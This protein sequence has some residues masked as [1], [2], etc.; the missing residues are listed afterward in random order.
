MCPMA[1]GVIMRLSDRSAL[2]LK[3]LVW[4]RVPSFL[5]PILLLSAWALHAQTTRE[6]NLRICLSGR[7]PTLC[8]HS[9]L[10]PDQLKLAREAE[11]RENLRVC[12]TG[13]FPSLCD[14][15]KLTESERRAVQ[16]AERQ[17][18][19]RVCLTGRFPTLCNHSRLTPSELQ[20]VRE[21]ERNENLRV[22]LD[23]RFPA[24][25]NKA[26][27]TPQERERATAAEAAAKALADAASARLG[28]RRTPRVQADRVGCESGHW[29]ESV[30][31]DGKIIKLEDGSMWEVDDVDTV[32]SSIWLPIS[33][34][35]VCNNKII[36]VD[37]GES[38]TASPLSPT[39]SGGGVTPSGK[40]A[41][42][43]DASH[44]DET[45]IINGEVFKAKT[46]CFNM[47]E[48]D[49]VVFLSGSAL[50]ACASAELLNLRTGKV[51]RVWCE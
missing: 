51:C 8:N 34:V 11:R 24:M 3:H 2:R 7:Y 27:L 48:G 10:T 28:G 33:E 5:I 46:Y 16:E 37:D 40:R 43:V 32:I 44:N 17:Q 41:Y 4:I 21:A 39:T 30:A 12:M 45:F 9:L 29:I 22:C 13:R 18:N 38:V 15:S 25:C 49:K 19:L 35:V 47:R 50:G 23:G 36:N 20:R 1:V 14:H 31:G 26:S 42:L 6:Q